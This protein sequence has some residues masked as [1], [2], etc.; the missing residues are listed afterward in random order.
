MKHK[1][2]VLLV[3]EL[4]DDQVITS[5]LL[6][7]NR[8]QK[9]KL[10]VVRN[11]EDGLA[12]LLECRHDVCLLDYYLGPRTG[13]ELIRKLTATNCRI[14]IILL[15][16]HGNRAMDIKAAKSGAADFLVKN[17]ITS[18]ILERSI[19]YAIERSQIQAS[20]D[21]A[22]QAARLKS[23][24]LANMS[25]EIRTPMNGIVGMTSL[26]LDSNLN[27]KQRELAKTVSGC[28]DSLLTIISDI[29]DLSKIEAGKLNF[30]SLSFDPREAIESVGQHFAREAHAKGITLTVNVDESVPTLVR[31]D[32]VR[33]R[34]V[35]TNLIGNA[36]KFTEKG[37]V[38]VD[39]TQSEETDEHHVLSFTVK[40]TGIGIPIAAQSKLFQALMQADES[41]TRKYGGTGLGLA[42]SKQLVGL[43]KGEISFESH[44]GNGARFSF[45]AQMKKQLGDAEAPTPATET[46]KP[47]GRS[48]VVKTRENSPDCSQNRATL[49]KR[50]QIL[51]VEDH[52]IN[53]AVAMGQLQKLDH[54]TRVVADGIEALAALE[55]RDY[56]II[57][58]DCQM[59]NLDGYEATKAIRKREG[60]GKHTV[61]IAMTANAMVGDR[62]V[63]IAAGMDDYIT[64]PIV[65]GELDLI[66]KKWS[67][68]SSE[69]ETQP[70]KPPSADP[71]ERV[72]PIDRQADR[73]Y[74][75]RRARPSR[76]HR[77]VSNSDG[78]GTCKTAKCDSNQVAR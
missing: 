42:I 71:A 44:P 14:P 17:D 20:R 51:V 43:M 77:I 41:T 45:T 4:G 62:E 26:L 59:P 32:A 15:T 3:E 68:Q 46:V 11:Y 57:L 22:V 6:K 49:M 69:R 70:P 39:V 7:S 33:L 36:V 24:F 58:M 29:L 19:R 54:K 10:E 34:Q 56:D 48:A 65:V 50:L 40:D 2:K 27:N 1:I 78:G 31:G 47:G 28:A 23:E 67:L 30:E 5:E 75:R 21:S 9:Y 25:H 13:L 74:R 18:S 73:R 66:I 52:V 55:E 37:E 76:I 16:G 8:N 63:C 12:A 60:S 38:D 53:Q 35:V 72:P 61:I 64:K